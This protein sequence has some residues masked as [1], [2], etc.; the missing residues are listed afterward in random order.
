MQFQK[1]KKHYFH[2]QKRQKINFPQEKKFKTTKNAIFGH[3]SE[4]KIHF[5]P[6]LKMQIMCF[7]LLKLHFFLIL[8]HYAVLFFKGMF[9]PVHMI[10]EAGMSCIR[11][12]ADITFPKFFSFMNRFIMN[13]Q[14][15]FGEK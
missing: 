5:L 9:L 14:I 12:M 1:C 8:E 13:F 3:F 11:C 10:F 4:A 6:F 2:F 7:L 15:V